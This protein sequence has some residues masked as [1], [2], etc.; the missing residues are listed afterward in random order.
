MIA[1]INASV[2]IRQTK[3]VSSAKKV[4]QQFGTL[5]SVLWVH[6]Q[7]HESPFLKVLATA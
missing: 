5:K 3:E 4:V 7:V 6:G 2:N 1:Y